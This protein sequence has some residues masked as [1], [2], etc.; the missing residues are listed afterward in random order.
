M[1]K[2]AVIISGGVLDEEFILDVLDSKEGA[3]IIGVDSGV[4]FLYKHQ[5]MPHYIVGD[6]DSLD[7]SIITYYRKETKVSIREFN[8]EKD[9]ADTEIA[10]KLAVAIGSRKM[11]ILGATGARIDHLWANIQTLFIAQ[12]AGVDAEILDPLNRI[13]IIEGATLLKKEA[14]YGPFFSVFTL[15]G[16]VPHF[17]IS[18]AKYPL[19]DHLLEPVGSL[20]VSN[21]YKDDVTITFPQGKVILMETRDRGISSKDVENSRETGYN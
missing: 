14:A 4:R 18:G 19:T 8:P 2:E 3:Y 6:F 20:C 9:A 21:E 5:I 10:V 13:R 17:N 12:A 11:S 1:S 16:P 7:E 15:N